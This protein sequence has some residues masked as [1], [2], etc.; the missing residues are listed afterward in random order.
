MVVRATRLRSTAGTAL[1]IAA[2]TCT[3]SLA[4]QIPAAAAGC[5]NPTI[6]VL[7]TL[8]GSGGR[9]TALGRGTIAAGSSGGV[10]VYWIGT[11][12]IKVPLAHRYSS[13]GTVNAINRHDLMVG[14]VYDSTTRA[15]VAFSYRIGAA[16]AK[17]LPGGSY[18]DDVNDSGR[19]VGGGPFPADRLYVWYGTAVERELT[20][21]PGFSY[22]RVSGINNA[23]TVIGAGSDY[24]PGFPANA[25]VG[26]VWQSGTTGPA[27]PLLPI[28]SSDDSGIGYSPEDIDENGRIVGEKDSFWADGAYETYWDA[29]Y[30]ADG[31]EV[32]GLPGYSGE[33]YFR[34]ISPTTGLVAG[35]A[36]TSYV[37]E[38]PPGV[39]EIWTGSGPIRPLPAPDPDGDSGA[40]SVSDNGD[41]GGFAALPS[42]DVMPVVWTCA[43]QQAL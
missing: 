22:P 26:L 8:N 16:R 17:I 15:D 3:M 11:T 37:G 27:I 36:P 31:T 20:V 18:A 32:P 1:G 21:G 12:V 4:P 29:P 7:D 10:P 25:D 35:E 9:V 14:T 6:Q 40:L 28:D 42:G 23:G 34:A 19:I 43:A 13:Y 24:Q 33:G 30:T 2:L 38:P 41:V 5:A 39:A